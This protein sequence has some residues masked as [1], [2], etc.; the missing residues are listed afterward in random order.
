MSSHL[1]DQDGNPIPD[2]EM[3]RRIFIET[4]LDAAYAGQSGLA[5]EPDPE[6][7]SVLCDFFTRAVVFPGQ[8]EW[9]DGQ[10]HT[11]DVSR[12]L[13]RLLLEHLHGHH[14]HVEQT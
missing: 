3:A 7:F 14:L 4:V 13:S 8:L 10:F 11:S 2:K 6:M 5:E 9:D 12:A 1:F